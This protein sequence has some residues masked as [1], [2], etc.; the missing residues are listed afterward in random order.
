MKLF[1]ILNDFQ[2]CRLYF[3]HICTMHTHQLESVLQ[4]SAY[5]SASNSACKFRRTDNFWDIIVIDI[6]IKQIFVVLFCQRNIAWEN[7]PS[8]FFKSLRQVFCS[9][10]TETRARTPI[11]W[12]IV[13]VRKNSQNGCTY[14]F[15]AGCGNSANSKR[16]ADFRRSRAWIK[17]VSYR[18]RATICQHILVLS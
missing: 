12:S 8:N 14:F 18:F 16:V 6:F 13:T 17:Q 15:V 2:I 9:Y 7:L 3:Y 1:L 11:V 5:Q 4:A 10:Q